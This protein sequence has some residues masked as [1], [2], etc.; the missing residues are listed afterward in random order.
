MGHSPDPQRRTE[1]VND[2]LRMSRSG[3]RRSD[4]AKAVY[5]LRNTFVPPELKER[6]SSRNVS[7]RPKA[8]SYG[9][10]SSA[11]VLTAIL[12]SRRSTRRKNG[13]SR[14]SW[15][16]RRGTS[17]CSR[18]SAR[19]AKRRSRSQPPRGVTDRVAPAASR[20]RRARLDRTSPLCLRLA[21]EPRDG[22]PRPAQARCPGRAS[23]LLREPEAD[24]LR[25]GLRRAR[26]G[27]RARL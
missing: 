4:A 1:E 14:R 7:R 22:V 5:S 12:V 26:R 20:V 8:P 27:A 21:P 2:E 24:P 23:L 11:S 9:I 18:A 3:D 6:R 15:A 13:V 25:G 17:A 16:R 19:S 10:S